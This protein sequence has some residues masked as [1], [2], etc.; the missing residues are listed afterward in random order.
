M[1]Y[2]HAICNGRKRVLPYWI[3]LY[4]PPLIPA[5][6]GKG[7]PNQDLACFVHYLKIINTV[8]CIL[9]QIV[10]ETQKWHYYKTSRPHGSCRAANLMRIRELI[11]VMIR[12]AST[13]ENQLPL[14]NQIVIVMVA[15]KFD[16]LKLGWNCT[17]V[18]ELLIKTGKILFWSIT[19][20]PTFPLKIWTGWNKN[21]NL[22]MII[23]KKEKFHTTYW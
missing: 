8:I 7:T 14:L 6:W 13:Y 2:V 10:W 5:W 20:W 1:N 18:L 23:Q 4:L 3:R 17:P 22:K 21:R 16:S 15:I 9:K 11:L 19:A 12:V